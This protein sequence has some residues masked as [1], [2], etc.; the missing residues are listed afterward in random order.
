MSILRLAAIT[1]DIDLYRWI[2]I[3]LHRDW[4]DKLMLLFTYTGDGHIQIPL[5]L[6]AC[7]WKKTRPYGCRA[8]LLCLGGRYPTDSPR[9]LLST[10]PYES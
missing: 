10:A 1:W 3:G 6:A 4:L 9:S 8:G 2:H 7:V 5:L